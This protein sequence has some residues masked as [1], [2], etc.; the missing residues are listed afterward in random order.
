[1]PDLLDRSVLR[2]ACEGATADADA[3]ERAFVAVMAWGYGSIGYGPF[4]TRNVLAK[5]LRTSDRLAA[6]ARTLTEDGAVAAY[7]RLATNADCRLRGFGPAF[8]TK[9]LVAAARARPCPLSVG[10]VHGVV[11]QAIWR[12]SRI[13]AELNDH[14]WPGALRR[15]IV[16]HD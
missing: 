1:M 3:A 12:T 6:V 8:G 10:S 16:D 9:Y 14:E 7:E 15:S 4:R 2:Y 13:R 11:D 5:T